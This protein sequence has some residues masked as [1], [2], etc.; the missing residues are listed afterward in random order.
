MQ[1]E[2]ELKIMLFPENITVFLNW[3]NQ[4]E[5]IQQAEE[6]LG[7]TY[8]DSED[9][10][11]A[12]HKMGLRVRSKNDQYEIT[13]KMQ[14]DIVGG[15]HIRP[16]YN[17]SL[18]NTFPDF[19][20]LVDHYQLQFE[21]N[22]ILEKP[23]Y[24]TFSTDFKRNKW[25]IH[26]QNAEIEIALD[27]GI[28]KNQFGQDPICEIELELKQGNLNDLFKLL[29]TMPTKDGMWL[30]SLSKAQRGYWIGNTEKI[31]KEC[32]K[33]TACI[34]THLTPIEHY[35]L[36]Q[37]FA[38]FIRLTKDMRLIQYYQQLTQTTLNNIDELF[39]QDYLKQQLYLMQQFY[40]C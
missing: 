17:L 18:A 28:I 30:S 34:S 20:Q 24:P 40:L 6:T 37:Q 33:L 29:D 21:D 25:L 27:Q 15:L 38:D 23:L 39:S 16:E 10:Y 13:L 7:N 8:Y 35:Q 5:I 14:G 11:F 36:T 32:E 4:Q 1:N 12:Q 2:I 31:A 9:H 26:F 19:K 3:I 22:A